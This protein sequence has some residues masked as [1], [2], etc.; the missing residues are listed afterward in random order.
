MD[1]KTKHN[2]GDNVWVISENKIEELP[3]EEIYVT[4]SK[5]GTTIEYVIRE[6]EIEED[7]V[8]KTKQQLIK[9]L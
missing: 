8:F 2:I 3:V 4:I 7:S 9:S 1:I 6:L 5:H